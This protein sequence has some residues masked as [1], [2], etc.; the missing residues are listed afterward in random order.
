MIDLH[1]HI[2]AGVDDGSDSMEESIEMARIAVEKGTSELVATPHYIEGGDSCDYGQVDIKLDEFRQELIKNGIPLKV[3]RGNEI[4]L[5]LNMVK[6]IESK[7]AA[8]LAGSRYVLIEMP[9][10]DLPHYA[11]EVVHELRLSGYIPII[12]HP[13][14]NRI[15]AKDPNRLLDFLHMGALAQLNGDSLAGRNGKEIKKAAETMLTHR[16]VHFIASDGHHQSRRRP[17]L[18]KAFKAASHLVGAKEAQ[19]LLDENP[20]QVIQDKKIQTEAPIRCETK[21]GKKLPRGSFISFW[22]KFDK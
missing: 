14:R 9:F 15:M 8:A 19:R 18:A 21:K 5:A 20:R 17:D 2:L 7:K 1:C 6:L 4:Y 22:N 11:E 16:M 10:F 13:E 12:A 3:H